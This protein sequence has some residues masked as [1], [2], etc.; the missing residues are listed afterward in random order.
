MYP[1]R[2]GPCPRGAPSVPLFSPSFLE[3][4]LDL[5]IFKGQTEAEELGAPFLKKTRRKP[6][7]KHTIPILKLVWWYSG[8]AD[9]KNYVSNASVTQ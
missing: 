6:A 9:E 2:E 8:T 4:W 7:C 3:K 5:K 1:L